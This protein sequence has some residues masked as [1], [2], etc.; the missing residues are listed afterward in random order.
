MA[1]VQLSLGDTG[2]AKQTAEMARKAFQS[3]AFDPDDAVAVAIA[4]AR[5][6]AAI[7]PRAALSKLIRAQS[8]AQ[9][10]GLTLRTFE[11]RLALAEI[12]SRQG[13]TTEAANLAKEAT[14]SGLPMFAIQA[15]NIG[16]STLRA[17]GR[18]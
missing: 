18:N 1:I 13:N 17:A 6:E 5:I 3:R 12:Q 4:E 11:A 9:K 7:S 15:R 8:D 2:G 10:S 14:Q 16:S